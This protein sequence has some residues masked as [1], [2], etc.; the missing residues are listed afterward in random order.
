MD[1]FKYERFF[2]NK[3]T[4]DLAIFAVKT[5]KKKDYVKICENV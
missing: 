2:V 4:R 3:P 5:D 1:C